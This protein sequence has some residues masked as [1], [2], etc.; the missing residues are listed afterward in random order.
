MLPFDIDIAL[1]HVA[2]R[3]TPKLRLLENVTLGEPPSHQPLYSA[4]NA[5]PE[6]YICETKRWVKFP[7]LGE[8]AHESKTTHKSETAHESEMAH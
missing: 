6:G 3:G 4:D 7:F 1:G 2:F 8:T 5:P